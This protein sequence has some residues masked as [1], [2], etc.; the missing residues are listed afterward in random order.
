MQ[1]QGAAYGLGG[2]AGGQGGAGYTL[3]VLLK[4][5]SVVQLAARELFQPV[6]GGAVFGR[7]G[8]S[9]HHHISHRAVRVHHDHQGFRQ[10]VYA[11]D[12]E[13]GGAHHDAIPGG[14]VRRDQCAGQG[15][16]GQIGG[17]LHLGI[18]QYMALPLDLRAWKGLVEGFG[19]GEVGRGGRG[20]CARQQ[21]E[22]ALPTQ[23]TPEFCPRA[24]VGGASV[25]SPGSGM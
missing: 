1:G 15:F 4:L 21:E 20:G 11:V 6:S 2:G 7:L 12:V 18:G 10:R 13:V 22:Q 24:P 8:K 19:L 23:G 14:H 5:Q 9:Q 25:G 3:D 16:P 17:L